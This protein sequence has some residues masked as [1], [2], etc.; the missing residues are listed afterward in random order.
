MFYVSI[1]KFTVSGIYSSALSKLLLDRGYQP[2]KLSNTLVERLGGEG[3]GKDEPDVVIKDM[4]RWQGVIVIG[5]QAKTVAD[6]IVQELGTV[7]Q[8]YLPKMYGAVF[9]PSVVERI[10]NGVI[11]ELEDRRGLLKTRGDNVGL[12]QVT[13]YARSVSKLLVTPAVRIRFGGA[14]AERTGRLIE[15]PPLPSGWRWRRRASDEENTQVASK[16]NDLEEMLTSPEIP[17]GRCVLPGKDY[18]ELVFGLEA[19]EL[20]D[21]WRSKITP[22]IH[23]HHY[24]KSLGPEY[25]A[26]V[27]FAEAVR[28]R[29]EDKLDEYL[30]DTVVKGVYPRSGEEVKIFHMKPDGN[31]VELSSGYVLHSDENTI[32]VKRPIK[33]RGEYDGI[34]AERRIGDYAITEF[35]LKEW[36]YVTTYF[37]RDGAEIGKYANVCTPPEVSKVFIR[38]IDLFVDVVKSHGEVKI[39]DREQLEEAIH[40]GYIT[41]TMYKKAVDTADKLSRE[42]KSEKE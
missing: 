41:Q 29:I 6:T 30:K 17:D 40:K 16:A 5:D 23:G 9:K 27:Y 24:L 20:L 19:K 42:L 36:Y 35:K 13:G 37:R 31:D 18:V 11:L 7:A 4:S 28:E 38:Y 26:L 8:F 21:V 39:I 15:D 1:V 32:I 2:T 22:T 3:A 25:S 10:R 12:V 14:E 33:S 34:E